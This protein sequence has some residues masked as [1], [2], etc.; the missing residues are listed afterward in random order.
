[1]NGRIGME[2]GVDKRRRYHCIPEDKATMS[3]RG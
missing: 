1:M 2:G 3:H